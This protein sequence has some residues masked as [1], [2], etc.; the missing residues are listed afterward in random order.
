MPALPETLSNVPADP[1]LQPENR[2]AHFS[3]PIVSPPTPNVS[4]PV[5]SHL[6]AGPA[7]IAAPHLPYLGL[8]SP[9]TFRRY[10]DSVVAIQ[11]K[12]QELAFLDPPRAALG[13]I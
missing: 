2:P 7:L 6:V 5:V 12:A 10:S 9:Q 13:D 1:A 11:S 3:Q 4:R 8:E